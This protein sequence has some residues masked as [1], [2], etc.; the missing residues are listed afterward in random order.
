MLMKNLLVLSFFPAFVPPKSGGEVRLFYFYREL[1]KS[2]RVRLISSGLVGEPA[3]KILHSPSFEEIRVGKEN[4]FLEAWAQLAPSAGAGDL[5]APSIAMTAARPNG[6]LAAYLENYAWADAVVHESPF[7]YNLDVYCGLDKKPRV[8][9]S[10]N[11]ESDLYRRLHPSADS[12]PIHRLVENSEGG[13]LKAASLVTYC[14]DVD[15][16][17]FLRM[18]V[19][20]HRLAALPNG[21]HLAVPKRKDVASTIK[22][23]VFVGSAHLPN[24]EAARYIV[25]EI[26]PQCEDLS[27]HIIGSCLPE[28]SYAANVIRHGLVETS[29]KLELLQQADVAINPMFE[30]GGSSLK[31]LDFISNGVPVLSTEVGVRGFGLRPGVDCVVE[32]PVNFANVLLG[33]GRAREF[34]AAKA[35]AALDLVREK[36]TWQRLALQFQAALKTMKVDS[37]VPLVLVLNDFDPF[38]SV[39]GGATRLQGSLRAFAKKGDVV[40]LH[41][42]DA[43]DITKRQVAP[44]IVT[45]G[46][47]KTAAHREEEARLNSLFHVSTSDIVSSRYV[48]ANAVLNEIYS[49]LSGRAETIICE[50][51]YLAPLPLAQG[52]AYIYSSQNNETILKRE[53]LKWHPESVHLIGEIERLEAL[54]IERATLLIA[55]SEEDSLGMS[56]GKSAGPPSIVVPNGATAPVEPSA[57]DL[58]ELGDLRR[59]KYAVFL[60]SAHMP[61]VEAAMFVAENL[62]PKVPEVLFVIVGSVC[63]ALQSIAAKN[64]VLKGVVA[65]GLKSAILQNATLALNPMMSGSGSNVKLADFLANGLF[66]LSTE[67]G[68]RGYGKDTLK[69]IEVAAL[70]DFPERIGALMARPELH[71]KEKRAERKNLFDATLSMESLASRSHSYVFAPEVPRKK[72]LFVTYRYG[73]PLRGGAEAMLYHLLKALSDSGRFDVD[74]ACTDVSTIEEVGRFAARYQPTTDSAPPH[75][76]RVR[77]RRFPCDPVDEEASV[78]QRARA[79][80]NAQIIFEREVFQGLSAADRSGRCLAWGWG[81]PEGS[82]DQ[83]GRWAMCES[84]LCVHG[85]ERVRLNGYSPWPTVLMIESSS[86]ELLYHDEVRDWFSIEFASVGD[87]LTISSS[88]TTNEDTDTRPLGVYVT[89]ILLD[90]EALTL[91]GKVAA[92]RRDFDPTFTFTLLNGASQTSRDISGISLTD[93]RGPFSLA[94]ER[95]LYQEA[96]SY[97]LVLTHNSIF[98]PA[99]AAV[100]AAKTFGV[101]S[102]LIPHAHLDD[103]F[104]HFGDVHG[105]ALDASLVLAAPQATVDFYRSLGV[106]NVGYLGAGIDSTDVASDA[107]RKRFREE[108]G[109]SGI[110]FLV[111]GRK[112]RAKGYP[113]IIEEFK[114]AG[115]DR[116]GVRLVMIGP[117]DDGAEIVDDSV[118][119]MGAQPREIVRGALGECL[120]LVNMSASESF[121]IVLLEAWMHDRPVI[122]N[123]DCPAFHDLAVDGDNAILVNAQTLG[124]AMQILVRDRDLANRLGGNG[125][126]MA[127]KYSWQS[128]GAEFVAR[129]HD[130]MV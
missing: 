28:G 102:I 2:C 48:T 7:T 76:G 89:G 46:V 86:G 93:I 21:M 81:A 126:S 41:L 42:T 87:V 1:S 56:A 9:A 109:F 34:W 24:V 91:T 38:Q 14:S 107:D 121:G 25:E 31:I 27:F 111:L 99:V 73:W 88:R 120:A 26:A 75:L 50:H 5:S 103:D 130:A 92:Q 49:Y 47:P 52:H 95:F 84:G 10:Y 123:R 43:H 82:A 65:E 16:L 17:A 23:V 64:V 127:T 79:A 115:L 62:A 96:G 30:G 6:L 106:R 116:H 58:A 85:A 36:F 71:T 112:A 11:F 67:F 97:D 51:P 125:R 55:V 40:C 20:V 129:C 83:T 44:G 70:A 15:H 37:P 63:G 4:D 19:E 94:L 101:P 29:R 33:A 13:L 61:N 35:T 105:A 128:I 78:S 18:G 59:R 32:D 90:G 77:Y 3:Q 45:I 8:Y 124:A 98:R 39:G 53:A 104:Y 60:G 80:W 69:H 119:Y 72:V 108:L 113:T 74:V 110:F 54:A 12:A 117:D 100:D 122:A 114:K 68:I 66:I 57:D 118:I 22:N